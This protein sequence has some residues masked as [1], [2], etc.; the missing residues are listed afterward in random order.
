MSTVPFDT[1]AY[2]KKLQA[3]GFTEAQAEV[4]AEAIAELVNEQ[5]ATK[6]DLKEL[7]T[8]L[9]RDLAELETALKREIKEL[10]LRLTVRL[11]AMFVAAVGVVAV[12]V[13]LL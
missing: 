9:Q 4:Q 8:T 6:R 2:V 7:E 5:L 11:G 12:L 1:H 10:E 3:A 13:K